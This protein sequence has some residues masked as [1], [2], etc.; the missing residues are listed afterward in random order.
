MMSIEFVDAPKRYRFVPAEDITVYELALIIS[1]VAARIHP[2][3]FE[4]LPDEVKRH[5]KE[6][7]DV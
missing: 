2:S 3:V 7:D 1:T 4:A 6:E 5:F